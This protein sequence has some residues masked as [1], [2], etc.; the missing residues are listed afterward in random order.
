MSAVTT[1]TWVQREK[2]QGLKTQ[3]EKGKFGDAV[4]RHGEEA[5][6]ERREEEKTKRV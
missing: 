1:A 5:D 4:V 2:F 3:G 6:E